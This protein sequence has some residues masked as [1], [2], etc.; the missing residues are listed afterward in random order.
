VLGAI[1]I[2]NHL[3]DFIEIAILAIFEELRLWKGERL[4]LKA[5]V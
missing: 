2:L 4:K 1:L 5:S 3:C